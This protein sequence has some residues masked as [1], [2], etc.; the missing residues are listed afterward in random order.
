MPLSGLRIVADDRERKSG[1]PDLL[2]GAGLDVEV[3]TLPVGDYIVASETI[4]ERKSL[5][6]FVS[7]VFDGRLFDQCTRMKEH[8]AHPALVVEGD[9]DDLPDLLE[10]P[11]VF[12]G[13]LSSV[14][15]EYRMPVLPTANAENTARLLAAMAARRPKATGPLVKKIRKYADVRRQQLG[16]VC[17]LPGIGEKLGGRML[18]RFG[19][20]GEALAASAAELAKVPG[21]GRARAG[22]IRGVLDSR[23]DRDDARKQGT[24]PGV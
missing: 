2:K 13:A 24:L 21:M 23:G 17:S 7:S 4:V 6:D 5:P 1:I 10:N 9:V 14:A 15:L 12:Y 22:R 11:L 8:F 16:I 20:P 18:E 19:T 3:R